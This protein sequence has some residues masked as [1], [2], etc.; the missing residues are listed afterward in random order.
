[1][2]LKNEKAKSE[3]IVAPILAEM[4]FVFCAGF[5]AISAMTKLTAALVLMIFM[6]V[7]EKIFSEVGTAMIF[8][9]AG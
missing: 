3:F 9:M 1:M 4:W 5:L 7:P 8:S 6:V 2:A